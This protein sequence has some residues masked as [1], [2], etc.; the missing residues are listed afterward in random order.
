ME[1]GSALGFLENR[2]ILVTGATGFLA[3]I[4]VEKILR[5]QPNVKKMYLLLRAA[6]TMA[7]MQRFNSEVMAKD[8]FKVVKDKYGKKLNSLISRKILVVAGDIMYENLGIKDTNLLDQIWREVDVVVNLAAT[9]NFYERY[10]VAMGINTMG[11]KHVLDFAKNCENLKIF[12]HVSTAYVSGEKEGLIQETPYQMG[13]TLNGTSGLDIDR[14]MKMI[15]ETLKNLRA[16]NNA[17]EESITSTMKELGIQR[18]MD[19]IALGYA[20]GKVKFFVGD[21]NSITD[22]IP[23]DMVVNAMIVAIVGHADQRGT[24]SIYH[25]G[26]SVSNPLEYGLLR[27]YGHHYFTKHP[28][29]GKD[30]KPIIVGK[31]TV[32][33]TM[34]S[35]QTY[36]TTRYLLPLKGL[37]ILNTIRCK[38][39]QKMY[40]EMDRKIKFVMK[41]VNLYRPYVY[42]KGVY[43]DLNTEKLRRAAKEGGIETDLFYFDPKAI[44]WED[45]FMKV[46]FPGLVKHV[47]K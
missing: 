30:G 8:L 47:F 18:T 12:L 13:E 24:E 41:L 36:M 27:D 32:L 23:A 19:S 28:W 6:D 21:P 43:D 35:F 34:A 4:F 46:H 31:M 25:V 39:F 1:L 10:D 33:S 26:S 7:A 3:K 42:F 15:K 14:E 11:A 29:I 22:L 44:S 37:E 20:K 16:E 40:D 17:S 45:Y 5:V 38:Y 2:A 9:T